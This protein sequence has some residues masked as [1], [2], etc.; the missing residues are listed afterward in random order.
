MIQLADDGRYAVVSESKREYL[1]VL[2]RSPQLLA[3]DESAI[4]SRLLAQG[5]NLTRWTAH[6]HTAPGQSPGQ[7]PR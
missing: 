5:F 1:W 6:A 7:A 3:A 2:S 4:R